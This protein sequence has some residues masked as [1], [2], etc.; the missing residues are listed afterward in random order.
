MDLALILERLRAS[1]FRDLAGA[2]VAVSAPLSESLLNDII[3]AVLPRGGPVRAA[4]V[5]PQDKNRLA[6]RV[7]LA[8]PE[9]LP[10]VSVTL[11]IERQP[12]LPHTPDL[13]L[14][15]LGLPGLLTLAGPFLSLG[16][17]LPPGVR[18]E[19]DVLTVNLAALLAQHGAGDLLGLVE[20]L[21]VRSEAGRLT[22]DLDAR[23]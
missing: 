15:V 16:S 9:F 13:V 1:G 12:A 22:I 3:A 5:H 10:P 17:I 2:R 7:K 11:A 21:Q 19:G 4:T 6:V 8:R 23:A 18:L 14:R 20:R